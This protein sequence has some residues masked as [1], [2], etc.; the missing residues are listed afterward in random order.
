MKMKRKEKKKKGT[1]IDF[2]EPE[3]KKH[4]FKNLTIFFV[5]SILLACSGFAVYAYQ[6][7][8][9]NIIVKNGEERTNVLTQVRRVYNPDIE[10]L[11]GEGEDRINILLLGKGGEGHEGGD[12]VDTIM[13]ASL[14]PSTGQIAL[15][16]FPRD[17]VVPIQTEYG[18][19][20]DRINTIVF[21]SGIDG[22]KKTMEEIT[23]LP[24]HYYAMVDFTGFR[25]VI[26]TIGGIRVYVENSFSDFSYPDYNYGYQT[27]SFQKGWDTFDGERALQYARSR[28]G[29]NGEDGDFARAKRQ[30]IILEATR[31]TVMSAS[32][33]LNPTR[34]SG[35]LQ[36]VEQHAELDM[37]IWEILKMAKMVE[38]IK[39][40]D[41]INGVVDYE[42]T[43]LVVSYTDADTG[44]SLIR[45]T[46]GENNYSEIQKFATTI[47]E[48]NTL[49][50]TKSTPA[51]E[52]AS[53]I[54][55]NGSG[56]EGLGY[57][58]QEKIEK[59]EIT[60][61]AVLNALISDS[62]HTIIYDFHPEENAATRDV[63]EKM[64]DIPVVQATIPNNP[65]ALVRL[66]TDINTAVIDIE[67]IPKDTDFIILLGSD[68][69]EIN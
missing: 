17:L 19:N 60:I 10:P 40:E 2:S 22:A 55:Q 41:I 67:N 69:A 56:I 39:R 31:D 24:I 32:T 53:I 29:D 52:K 51:E 3:K 16:S 68:A 61:A 20:Y 34:L 23:S 35:L 27:I 12:L 46:A 48:K 65:D 50:N 13:I 30:Q 26:N 43:G 54:I 8:N 15:L 62:T 66:S 25:D 49:S 4:P 33:F 57:T 59:K 38:N 28:K 44:A 7:T 18:T 63:L 47:F 42:T 9:Q 21:A 58:L 11:Q 14:K 45:P 64:F 36:D 1:R 6:F 5:T 37:E